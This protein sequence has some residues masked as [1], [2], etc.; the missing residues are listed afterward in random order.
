MMKNGFYFDDSS[1]SLGVLHIT[2][3]VGRKKYKVR[4]ALGK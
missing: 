3:K 2:S 1:L 4:I